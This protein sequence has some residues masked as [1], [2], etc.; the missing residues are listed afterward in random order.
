MAT[1]GSTDSPRSDSLA[2]LRA[3][4]LE[5]RFL[6]RLDGGFCTVEVFDFLEAEPGFDYVVA[7]A[8]NAVLPRDA[9]P[10]VVATRTE[11]A[12]GERTAHYFGQSEPL[13]STAGAR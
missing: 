8:K 5:A 3:E 9:E 7:M 2:L 13:R 4:F 12:L 11:N 6:V 10:A 1:I